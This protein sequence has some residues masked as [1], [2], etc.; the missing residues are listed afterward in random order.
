MFRAI[1]FILFCILFTDVCSQ[2]WEQTLSVEGHTES[3]DIIEDYDGGVI[4]LSLTYNINNESSTILTKYDINGKVLWTKRIGVLQDEIFSNMLKILE[5]GSIII[6]GGEY[7][8][9]NT[10]RSFLM[11]LNP[12]GELDWLKILGNHI[13]DDF[14]T[15][16]LILEDGNI[17]VQASY[18]GNQII[19]LLKLSVDGE[20]LWRKD[21]LGGSPESSIGFYNGVWLSSIAETTDKGFVL[22]GNIFT[23]SPTD[24][25]VTL[26]RTF[27]LKTDNI[28]TQ[29]WVYVYGLNDTMITQAAVVLEVDGGFVVHS[30]LRVPGDIF[31]EVTGMSHLF[32]LDKN[33]NFLWDKTIGD[34]SLNTYSIGA[35]LLN[36]SILYLITNSQI[37][38]P[39]TGDDYHSYIKVFKTDTFGTILDTTNYG[40]AIGKNTQATATSKTKDNKILISGF[41]DSTYRSAYILKIQQDLSI[42]TFT[43]EVLNYDSLCNKTITDG[44][45]AFDTALSII[46]IGSVE[47]ELK[48]YP[49]PVSKYI[50]FE[51][52][53]DKSLEFSLNIYSAIGSLVYTQK[54]VKDKL[55]KVNVVDLSSGIYYYSIG[56]KNE[57]VG[58]GKFVK[59]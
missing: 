4:V 37:G 33:G 50:N 29:E 52:E 3:R 18:L 57:L 25:F 12:C 59:Q 39:I 40:K 45:I 28:G 6:G 36:D 20:E 17:L 47:Y 5:D 15:D 26:S 55:L 23:L 8:S 51:I 19:T 21:Y 27:V 2:N 54:E 35:V 9:K 44:F 32:K 46:N 48:V 10:T 24:T 31:T 14:I 11:K 34:T 38:N 22:C 42:D 16:I 58:S 49:N 7:K 30:S 53:V 13:S 41:Q 56:Y 43:N 1:W